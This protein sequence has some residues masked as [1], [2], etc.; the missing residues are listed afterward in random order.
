[1]SGTAGPLSSLGRSG[2]LIDLPV[3]TTERDRFR[4][5]GG[6]NVGLRRTIGAGTVFGVSL[7]SCSA[8]SVVEFDRGAPE[9]EGS[10]PGWLVDEAERSERIGGCD[11][12]GL[13]L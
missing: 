6:R 2:L 7:P 8:S 5:G 11:A 3:L 10:P 13:I 12:V 9:S 4:A 1:M